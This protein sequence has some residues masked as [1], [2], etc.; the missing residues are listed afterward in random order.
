[1]V[2]RDRS[3]GGALVTRI[4]VTVGEVK[5]ELQ[6]V[7]VS[8]SQVRGLVR[9]AA[10]VH[11]AVQVEVDREEE[12]KNPVGFSAYLERLP[13]EIAQEDLSWYFDEKGKEGPSEG[14]R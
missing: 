10:G 1:M 12:P 8:V 6:D 11:Q 3:D 13:E 9:L 4:K 7:D 2:R 5:I 14:L